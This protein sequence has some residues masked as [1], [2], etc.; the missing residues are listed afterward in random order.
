M[1][2]LEIDE[3]PDAFKL[4]KG[5]APPWLPRALVVGAAALVVL[6]AGVAMLSRDGD[7]P[8][9][10]T[11]LE[12][13]SIPAGA[14]VSIDGTARSGVT[15]MTVEVAPATD[16]R[17]RVRAPRHEP[18]TRT[19]SVPAQGG[20][21]RVVAALKP[22]SVTLIVRSTPDQAEVFVNGRSMGRTPLTLQNLDPRAATNVEL[23]AR[24]YRPERRDLDWTDG[25]SRE[26][27]FVLQK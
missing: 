24:G 15:P 21:V 22:V 20:T 10:V 1:H 13:V 26:L 19:Q 5:G 3:L 11:R 2:A 23:R 8:P 7:P 4:N 27:V 12:I 14:A 17:I 9:A 18:W 16:Y 25:L 6:G